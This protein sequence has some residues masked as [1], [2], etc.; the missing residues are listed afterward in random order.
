MLNTPKY[1]RR[2]RKLAKEALR[3]KKKKYECPKC[4]KTKLVRISFGIWQCKSCG[5][6]FAGGAY[7]FSTDTGIV[8]KRIVSSQ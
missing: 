6:T 7:T 2:V 3:N 5:A 8:A 4:G 1:G